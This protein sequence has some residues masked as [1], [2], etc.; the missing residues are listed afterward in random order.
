MIEDKNQDVTKDDV[1]TPPEIEIMSTENQPVPP[2]NT[3][4][5]SEI[6]S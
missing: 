2:S 6:V 5:E 4:L 3:E 1:L